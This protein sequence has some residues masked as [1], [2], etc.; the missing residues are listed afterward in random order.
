MNVTRE[1]TCGSVVYHLAG[2]LEQLTVGGFRDAIAQILP[3]QHVIFDLSGVPFL[4][5]AGLGALI[6]AVRRIRETGGEAAVCG[7]RPSVNR[8]LEIVGL[9]RIVGVASSVADAIELLSAAV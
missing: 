5:S 1:E 4:D 8:A 6:G 7:P 9:H 2:N 3:K